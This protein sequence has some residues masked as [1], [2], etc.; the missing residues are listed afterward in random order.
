MLVFV[1]GKIDH[2]S[3]Y[4]PNYFYIWK[5]IF[6]NFSLANKS[7]SF[8]NTFPRK[9]AVNNVYTF[10]LV[11]FTPSKKGQH[12][13]FYYRLNVFFQINL[14]P[15]NTHIH[16]TLYR[17]FISRN[18]FDRVQFLSVESR[19]NCTDPLYLISRAIHCLEKLKPFY[20]LAMRETKDKDNISS[21]KPSYL[22]LQISKP[23]FFVVWV[24]INVIFKKN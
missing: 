6:N 14:T 9:L 1:D 8:S 24:H 5:V 11:I 23:Q 16:N 22:D 12:T 15:H 19:T 4:F 7:Q 13:Q 18:K 21:N 20:K 3:N 17:Q 2:N 10:I